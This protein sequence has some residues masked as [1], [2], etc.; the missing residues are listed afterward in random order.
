MREDDVGGYFIVG[1]LVSCKSQTLPSSGIPARKLLAAANPMFSVFAMR[2]TK[3]K[4]FRIKSALLSVDA[5]SATNTSLLTSSSAVTEE[6][7]VPI[8]S[9]VL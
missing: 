5:L 6:R 8:R 7:Q 2:L 4:F 1:Y 3:G 9:D